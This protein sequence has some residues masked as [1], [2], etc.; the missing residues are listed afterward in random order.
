MIRKIKKIN[1]NLSQIKNKQKTNICMVKKYYKKTL[2]LLIN[3]IFKE[4][5]MFK[6]LIRSY[7][8]SKLIARPIN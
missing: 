7:M 8:K 3:P 2:N 4:L 6:K 1:K 5:K